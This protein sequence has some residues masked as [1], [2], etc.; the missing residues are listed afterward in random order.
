ML[1]NLMGA[2]LFGATGYFVLDYFYVDKSNTFNSIIDQ[3]STP[4]TDTER[5]TGLAKGAGCFVIAI[6]FLVDF[7]ATLRE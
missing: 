1:Y 7:I 3:V 2:C 6:A 4:M 5:N